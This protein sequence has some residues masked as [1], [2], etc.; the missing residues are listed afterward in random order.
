MQQLRSTPQSVLGPARHA[1]C[2][3]RTAARAPVRQAACRATPC[4]SPTSSLCRGS[5]KCAASPGPPRCA[6]S[7]PRRPG[8]SRG[9]SNVQPRLAAACRPGVNRVDR[10]RSVAVQHN[11]K[12]LAPTACR[13]SRSRI[14]FASPREAGVMSGAPGPHT[15]SACAGNA[16][17]VPRCYARAK[18]ARSW[19]RHQRE[20]TSTPAR[21][22]FAR[23]RVTRRLASPA[24][25]AR[26]P[27]PPPPRGG[28]LL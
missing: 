4:R 13:A 21:P 20:G 23:E 5:G 7:A 22:R 16:R 11:A 26:A 28:S 8:R 18:S 14:R 1:A 19:L 6:F 17:R 12:L 24:L 9:N 27:L 2:S 3:H 15:P 25:L 10:S